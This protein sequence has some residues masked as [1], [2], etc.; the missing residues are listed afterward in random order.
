[1]K[2][3]RLIFFPFAMVYWLIT[4]T[5]NG[6]YRTGIMKASKFGL[7][8]INVGNLNMGGTGKTPHVE[9][10]IRLL[11]DQYKVATLSR[12]FGRKVRGFIIADENSDAV[13][14]GDEPL[15]YFK[16]YGSDIIVSVEADRV[17][18]AMDL[19]RIH[20]DIDVL[21]LDDAFQHRKID[22]GVNILCTTYTDPFFKD[23]ILPVGN[24]RESRSGKK[25]ADIIIVTKC[26]ELNDNQRK[27]IIRK[28]SQTENQAIFFSTIKYGEVT[29]FKGD[30]VKIKNRNLILVTGIANAQP[31]FEHLN[32]SGRII[33]HFK[34]GD[35]HNFRASEL[36]EIHNIFDK[37]ADEN[38]LIITTEKDA[39]RL[40]S[41]E[42]SKSLSKY[43]WAYQNI[44]V[45]I[46]ER[47]K[48]ENLILKYVKEDH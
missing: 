45:K 11:K 46:D 21:L 20:D 16:K 40:M 48:F 30:Q 42:H 17:L 22:R 8:V 47:E 4:S 37:F 12:G 2:F 34:F 44:E 6:F 23:F 9:Y 39:M 3:F 26:P 31:L 1:M 5:R 14:I 28:I 33:K 43:F 29:S 41:A 15:Q 24:L 25:R 32:K 38:P 35:H 27:N 36:D 13:Q 10:L 18:G 7:A 19:F